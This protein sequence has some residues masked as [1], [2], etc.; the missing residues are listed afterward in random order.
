MK[1]TK[2]SKPAL[3]P[4]SQERLRVARETIRSLSIAHPALE[5]VHGAASTAP[6]SHQVCSITGG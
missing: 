4:A 2:P 5:A 3:H 6:C 1:K